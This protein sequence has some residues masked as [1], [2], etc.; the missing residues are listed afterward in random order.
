MSDLITIEGVTKTRRAWLTDLSLHTQINYMEANP[1]WRAAHNRSDTIQIDNPPTG[2][3]TRESLRKGGGRKRRK[4]ENKPRKPPKSRKKEGEG[5]VEWGG[6]VWKWDYQRKDWMMAEFTGKL[7]GKT[8]RKKTEKAKETK[9]KKIKS[10]PALSDEQKRNL[11]KYELWN[12]RL[13]KIG[14]RD[15]DDPSK[16]LSPDHPLTR[17]R[18]DRNKADIAELKG[19]ITLKEYQA[20]ITRIEKR[21]KILKG[22][23]R[24]E[25]KYYGEYMV[26]DRKTHAV[27]QGFHPDSVYYNFDL[28]SA[29]SH[30]DWTAFLKKHKFKSVGGKDPDAKPEG[31]IPRHIYRNPDGVILVTSSESRVHMMAPDPEKGGMKVVKTREHNLGYVRFEVSAKKRA[32]LQPILKDFRG[33]RALTFVNRGGSTTD[34]QADEVGGIVTY[35]KEENPNTDHAYYI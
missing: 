33:P 13:T 23:K 30:A 2:T 10:E 11:K 5:T 29:K 24:K 21:E 28:S 32:K 7:K 3:K 15:P 27:N 1:M 26:G 16:T 25:V 20:R 9:K 18:I 19:E 31:R 4:G 12:E 35:V 14:M 8:G 6:A 17:A 34:Y 22:S